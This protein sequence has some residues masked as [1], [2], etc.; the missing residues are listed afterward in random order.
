[1]TPRD[2]ARS[3]LAGIL[4][5]IAL[6]LLVNPAVTGARMAWGTFYGAF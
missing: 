4:V 6:S 3:V 5:F 1:M 2:I